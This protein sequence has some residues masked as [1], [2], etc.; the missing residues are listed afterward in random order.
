MTTTATT[1]KLTALETDVLGAMY[2]SEYNDGMGRPSV[3]TWSVTENA[4]VATVKQISGVVSSLTKKGL[5]SIT[6]D[7]KDSF[8]NV[9]AKGHEVALAY[10]LRVVVDA[11]R[12]TWDVPA[13]APAVEAPVVV[14][15]PAAAAT[16]RPGKRGLAY[17]ALAAGYTLDEAVALMD[18]AMG[19]DTVGNRRIARWVQKNLL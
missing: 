9:T 19:E 15:A 4:R 12:D 8:T 3:W 18:D 1:T 16:P 13:A 10:G 14:E 11:E 6:E 7:G 5:L 17:E 2:R